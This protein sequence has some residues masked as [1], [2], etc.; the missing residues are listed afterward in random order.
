L[1]AIA[2]LLRVGLIQA[3]DRMRQSTA[4]N[5]A[6]VLAALAWPL[7]FYGAMSQLGDYAPS[8]PRE[9]IETNQHRST[10]ILAVGLLCWVGS[11]WLSGYSFTAAKIRA[12][13][14]SVACLV[15]L[16]VAIVGMWT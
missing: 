9:I 7:A 2:A 14:A 6:I 15:L 10:S 3:L 5:L 1:H 8:T 16:V 13:I 4:S 12:V 11:I